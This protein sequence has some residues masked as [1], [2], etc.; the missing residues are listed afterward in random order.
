MLNYT[1]NVLFNFLNCVHDFRRID[2]RKASGLRAPG[3]QWSGEASRSSGFIVE[4]ARVDVTI[5]DEATADSGSNMRKEA[6]IWMTESTIIN[7]DS[8]QVFFLILESSLYKF[9]SFYFVKFKTTYF[10]N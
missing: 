8:L 2:T 4:D 10:T 9:K 6:P 5:G 1:C 7:S 3:D